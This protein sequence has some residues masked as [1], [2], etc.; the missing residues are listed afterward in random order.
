MEL[1]EEITKLLNEKEERL[2]LV[3]QQKDL[4]NKTQHTTRILLLSHDQALLRTRHLM[5]EREGYDV[6]SVVSFH[7]ALELCEHGGF[8]VFVFGDSIP[9]AEKLQGFRLLAVTGEVP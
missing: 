1:V 6:V 2:K 3:E 9:H 7:T 5:L 8:D 4:L